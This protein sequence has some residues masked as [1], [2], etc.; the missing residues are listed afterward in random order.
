[1]SVETTKKVIRVGH[2]PDPDDAFMFYALAEGK[3]DSGEFEFQDVIEDIESLNKRSEKGELEVTAISLHAY[4]YVH[5]KYA[6]MT[7]GASLGDGYGPVVVSKTISDAKDLEG[8]RIAI[9]GRFTTATLLL[10]LYLDDFIPV[11]VPFDQIMDVV[12][13]GE[14]DAGLLIHEGQITFE[15]SGFHGLVDLGIWWKELYNLPLP[16]GLD[17]IRK[18]FSPEDQGKIAG[19]LKKSIEHALEDRKPALKYA[20]KYGRGLKEELADQFVGMYVNDQTLCLSP[21]AREAIDLLL[22]LGYEKKILPTRVKAEFIE[23][24]L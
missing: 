9:P 3:I 22:R 8:K 10:K 21:E 15:E 6:I 23:P 24:I 13:R 12:D 16:L 14:V 4:A 18:D 1:M 20:M 7:C 19:I 5:D 11:E 2:S 17:T